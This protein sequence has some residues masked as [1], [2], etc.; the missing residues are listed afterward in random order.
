MPIDESAI[1][2]QKIGTPARNAAVRI[3]SR[4]VVFHR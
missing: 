2:G 3:P 1:A 4:P